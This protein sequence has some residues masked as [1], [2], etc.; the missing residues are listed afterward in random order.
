[1]QVTRA[2]YS[3]RTGSNPNPNGLPLRDIV[4][5]F[6][7]VYDELKSDGYFDE[8]FGSC[9]VDTG[10]SQGRI[11]DINLEILLALHKKNLWPV[12]EYF[13]DYTEDDLLD[14]TEFLFQHVS[15]PIDG[16]Y[17]SWQDCGMHW[18]TFNQQ[19]GREHY[20]NRMNDVL[21]HYEHRFELSPDGQVLHRAEAGFE[22]IFDA[23]VPS[24]DAKVVSRIDAAVLTYRRHGS[25]VEERRQAVRD[26]VDVLEYLRPHVKTFLTRKDEGDLFNL[27]NNFGLRHHNDMQKTGYDAALWLSWMFYFY[28]ATIHVVLRKMKHGDDA[29]DP[30]A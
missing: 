6:V 5:I 28:L 27:A 29:T 8:A 17:H 25:T 15:K 30:A 21:A 10:E 14:L 18:E 24:D 9:C 1:M 12:A 11:T 3:Q 26:L 4:K 16:Q 19:A 2:Y 20:R 22:P 23:N 7:G 13:Q